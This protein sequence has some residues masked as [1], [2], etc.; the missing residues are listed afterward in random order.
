MQDL[1]YLWKISFN[2]DITEPGHEVIFSQE[3]KNIVYA[4][5]TLTILSA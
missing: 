1:A 2:P 4:H 3:T 5:F